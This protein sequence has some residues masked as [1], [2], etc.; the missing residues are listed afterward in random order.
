MTHMNKHFG[1]ICSFRSTNVSQQ[2]TVFSRNVTEIISEEVFSLLKI[3]FISVSAFFLSE[4]QRLGNS[5][6]LGLNQF[7]LQY[8]DEHEL[9]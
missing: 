7:L 1:S 5:Q 4:K 6:M 2:I 3:N 9:V 8:N